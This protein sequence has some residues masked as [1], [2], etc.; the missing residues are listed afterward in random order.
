MWERGPRGNNATCLPLGQLLVTFP[1]TYKQIGP[2]WCWFPGEWVCVHSRTLWVFPLI[3]PV[4]LRV[5]PTTATPTYFTSRGFEAYFSCAGT[6]GC[7]VCLNP[8]LLL[9]VYPHANVV[10]SAA[11]SPIQ[12]FSHHLA[13]HPLCPSCL[14]PLLLPVWMNVS[15]FNSLV[16]RFPYSS[17]FCQFWL[18]SVVKF[19]VV[20]LLVVRGGTVCLPTPPSLP[21]VP[22]TFFLFSPFPFPADN[23][24]NDLLS[25]FCSVLVVCLVWCPS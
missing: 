10:L 13:R 9:L 22:L 17:V 16:V 3:S 15:F 23:P 8:Q 7:A 14:S 5:S 20:L 18:L 11:T 19:V 21:E 4:R 6:F 25:W 2:F 1:T 24:P 12:S